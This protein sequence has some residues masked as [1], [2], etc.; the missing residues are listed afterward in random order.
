MKQFIEMLL[1]LEET[2]FRSTFDSQ[3]SKFSNYNKKHIIVN[4]AIK[5]KRNTVNLEVPVHGL[6]LTNIQL[7]K[8]LLQ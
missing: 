8:S 7:G 2:Q 6:I 5:L 3:S 1:I 4:M